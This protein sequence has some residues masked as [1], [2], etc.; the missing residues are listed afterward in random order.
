MPMYA[1][2]EY[3]DNYFVTSG[4]LWNYYRDEIN[5]D[6]NENNAA[7]NRVNKKTTT[8]KSFEYNTKLIGSVPNNNNILDTEVDVPL[9]YL[10]NFWRSLD[11]S[12]INCKIELD[13]SWS[14]ECIISEISITAAVPGNPDTNPPAP[15]VAAIQ[16]TGVTFQTNIAKRYVPVVMLSINDHTK[17]L[18]NTKQGFKRTISWNKYRPEITTQPKNNNLDYMIDPTFKSSNRSFVL[19][20][21]NDNDDPMRDSFDE[22][23]MPLVEIKIFKCIN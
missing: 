5:H 23:Y 12:L 17:F 16:T 20:F 19:S 11:L 6:E 2:L 18:E 9:K 3:S 13:L 8:T 4:S 15:D 22:Y 21:K 14:K 1:L 10:I 7:N